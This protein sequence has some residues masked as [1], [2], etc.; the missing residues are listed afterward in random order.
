M[1][2][3]ER[4]SNMKIGGSTLTAIVCT[5]NSTAEVLEADEVYEGEWQNTLEY[6]TIV[7][8]IRVSHDSAINGLEIQWSANGVDVIQD[9]V[10]TL[11]AS[12]GKVFTFGPANKY[13]R[14]RYT[15]GD[16]LQTL[17]NL[18]TILRRTYFKPSSHRIQDSIIDEDDAE[19]VKSVITGLD[20]L[21]GD[22]DNVTAYRGTLNSNNAYVHRKIVSEM[23]SRKTGDVTTLASPVSAGATSFTVDNATGF[24]T[25]SQ[26]TIREG[27]KV[28]LGIITLT[29]VS[30]VIFTLDRPLGY[31][32]TV[33]AEIEEVT[34]DMKDIVGS[35]GT[36]IIFKITPP[37]GTIWQIT[38]IFLSITD[39]TAPD[40]GKFGG[41]GA[42][43]NGVSLRATTA[44]G[45]IVVYANWKNNGD[46]KLDMYDIS[47]SDKAP[48]GEHGVNGMWTFTKAEVVAELDGDAIP[49]QS[50]EILIQDNITDLSSFKMKAQGRVYSP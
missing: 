40:D 8:A 26:I 44:A 35:L 28:E 19:L 45:R 12:A 20:V 30:G 25:G 3:R 38:R 32:Y 21:T 49:A 17:F 24:S 23:F 36:P 2:R 37:S 50:L 18:Q 27:I 4:G 39:G 41:I 10:F 14:I 22:F 7:V 34:T 15:N 1:G 47:Y 11:S 46:M 13:F 31:D 6:G 48:A 33:A 29:D 42:L 16:T 5:E 43:T 9:D